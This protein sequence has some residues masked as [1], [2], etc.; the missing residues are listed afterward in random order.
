MEFPNLLD[1]SALYSTATSEGFG[2][3]IGLGVDLILSTIIGGI[4]LMLILEIFSHKFGENIRPANAFLVVLIA[5]IINIFGVT[6]ILVSFIPGLGMFY[7]ILP[8]LV[9]IVLIKLFFGGLSLI[10]AA[11]VGVLFFVL[12]IVLVPLL[13]SYVSA[14]I[15]SFG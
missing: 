5:N 3:W 14:F 13:T 9:W 6:G 4:V 10:Q 1:P 12:T 11:V 15:P 8:V 7:L 2:Y